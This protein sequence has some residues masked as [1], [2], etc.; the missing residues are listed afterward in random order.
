MRCHRSSLEVKT[1]AAH[2]LSRHCNFIPLEQDVPYSRKN[3]TL[4]YNAA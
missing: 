3:D 4:Q 2:F 1:M